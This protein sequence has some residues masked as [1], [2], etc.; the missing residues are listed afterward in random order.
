MPATPRYS[1]TAIA[2]HWLMAIFIL[3]N[4]GVGLYMADLHMSMLRLKLF[5]YHKWVGASLLFLAAI[6]LLWRLSHRPPAE[7]PAPRWQHVA[8]QAT[9]GA[10]YALFFAVPLV[11][12]AYSSALGFPIVVFGLIPLPDFV[13]KDHDLAE[14][15][16]PWHG[17]LAWAM[18]VLVGL[19]LAA[20]AKHLLVDRD[21]LWRRML[22]G[23]SAATP[24]AR[25]SSP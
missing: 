11:G 12:W 20:V 14:L 21:G 2:L 7:L 18:I 8:A 3:V 23:R 17:R 24:A 1:S 6:R 15:I 9:H 19:H 22:P 5:N 13:P 25:P 10:L 4:F 16:K